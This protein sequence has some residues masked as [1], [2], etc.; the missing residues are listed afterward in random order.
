MGGHGGW[1]QHAK[2]LLQT[3][4]S[5]IQGRVTRLGLNAAFSKPLISSPHYVSQISPFMP[6]EDAIRGSIPQEP[7]T[8][9]IAAA[10]LGFTS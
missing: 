6:I 10:P 4:R 3:A 8:A 5:C 7:E 9:R 1:A 2:G